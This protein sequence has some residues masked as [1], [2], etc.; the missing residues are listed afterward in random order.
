MT[1]TRAFH[2]ASMALGLLLTARE[3]VAQASGAVMMD[4]LNHHVRTSSR[5]SKAAT[6]QRRGTA[7]AVKATRS[8]P[9]LL[10]APITS[11]PT[12]DSSLSAVVTTPPVPT[13]RRQPKAARITTGTKPPE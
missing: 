4:S 8:A 2:V 5:K 1:I 9:T 7:T 6:M 10:T 13:A 3:A 11:V 12:S